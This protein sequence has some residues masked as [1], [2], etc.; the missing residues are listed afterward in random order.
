MRSKCE[1][2]RSGNV[3]ASYTLNRGIQVIESLAF[4]D[5]STDLAANTKHG[6]ATLNDDQPVG[7]L[8]G[9]LNG[10]D[11]E[12][13]NGTEVDDLSLDALFGEF[14]SGFQRV[15]DHLAMGDDGYV[16]SFPLDL[17][18]SDGDKEFVGHSLGGHW[19]GDTVEHLVLQ[20]N[21]WIG[22]PDGRLQNEWMS[23]KILTAIEQ[24]L[25]P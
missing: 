5:L 12:R 15:S 13:A 21:D 7:L 8:D 11:V 19:E 24:R 2:Y 20:E 4:D 22:I 14:L 23:W 25:I 18:L 3:S 9:R 16:A 10:V 17:G 6:E 1:T